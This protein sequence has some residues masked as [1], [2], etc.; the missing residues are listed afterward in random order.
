MN[1]WNRLSR[2]LVTLFAAP[3]V[4]PAAPQIPL[5]QP[6]AS[7]RVE[8]ASVTAFQPFEV[9][10][11]FA[12]SYCLSPGA[13]GLANAKLRN[14][15]LTLVISHLRSGPC[16]T[17]KRVAVDGLPPG[18]FRLRLSVTDTYSS[19]GLAFY[20]TTYEKE[21]GEIQLT[22]NDL[23]GWRTGSLG[24]ASIDKAATPG[25]PAYGQGPIQ[26]NGDWYVP[27][28]PVGAPL[29][30]ARPLGVGQASATMGV[31]VSDSA[32]A[33]NLPTPFVALY[34]V[35]YPS[36]MLGRYYTTAKSTCSALANAWGYDPR[37]MCVSATAV[38]RS[39]DGLTC[40]LGTE[41]VFVLFQPTD[42]A[43]RYTMDAELYQL[44]QRVSGYRGEGLGWC[45]VRPTNGG[46]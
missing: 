44:L 9:V 8:P 6:L 12:S 19:S 21:A 10:A 46:G 3:M 27:Q 26:L 29:R 1:V 18:S 32:D 13:P 39:T 14:G 16:V 23:P 17:E 15:I 36:G 33:A 31:F 37:S 45:A 7:L 24:M 4:T 22:I 20:S 2:V 34:G 41:P 5:P 42:V 43:H 30:V 38:V 35:D 25:W 40:P 11:Q 28:L